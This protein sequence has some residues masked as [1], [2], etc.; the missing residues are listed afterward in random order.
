MKTYH[1]PPDFGPIRPEILEPPDS[2]PFWLIRHPYHSLF[3][4][5]LVQSEGLLEDVN[6]QVSDAVHC[7]IRSVARALVN[8]HHGKRL[9]VIVPKAS[10]RKK[11]RPRMGKRLSPIYFSQEVQFNLFL[12]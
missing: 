5:Y 3:S 2:Q 10:I 12:N 6:T 4:S 7:I 1:I 9:T 8:W 11:P